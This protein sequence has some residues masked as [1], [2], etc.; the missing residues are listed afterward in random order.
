MARWGTQIAA[1]NPAEV[2]QV[3]RLDAT[4]QRDPTIAK[5]REK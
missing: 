3:A 1:K 2:H 5:V 4:A